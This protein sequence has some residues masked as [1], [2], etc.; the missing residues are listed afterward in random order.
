MLVL[1][2]RNT[3]V[4]THNVQVQ[5]EGSNE[6]ILKNAYKEHCTHETE[7]SNKHAL[8]RKDVRKSFIPPKKRTT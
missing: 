4:L 7:Y 5:L 6:W 1:N 3:L 8:Y 2:S